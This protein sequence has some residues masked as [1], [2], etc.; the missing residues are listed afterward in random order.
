MLAPTLIPFT[1]PI[2][3]TYLGLPRAAVVLLKPGRG[4]LC[5]TALDPRWFA[6]KFKNVMPR[7][8]EAVVVFDE[9]LEGA[10]VKILLVDRAQGT[11]VPVGVGRISLESF[12]TR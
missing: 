2:Y 7:D 8:Y 11:E 4:L 3:A 9:S 1:R 5:A 12:S 10:G 6:R